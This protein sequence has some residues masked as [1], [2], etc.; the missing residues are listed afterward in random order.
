MASAGH[1]AVIKFRVL[2]SAIKLARPASAV[3]APDHVPPAGADRDEE[4][5]Q[6]VE[7]QKRS[8]VL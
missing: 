6:F 3:L 4:S 2:S 1:E 8:R 5:P 7:K